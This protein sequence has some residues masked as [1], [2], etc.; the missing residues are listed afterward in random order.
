MRVRGPHGDRS[1]P[2]EELFCLPGDT[3]HIEH[4]LRPGELLLEVVVPMADARLA[5]RARYLKVRDRSSYEFAVVSAAAALAI[6]DGTIRSARIACGGVGT[7]PWRMRACE[8]ALVGRPATREAFQ[9]AARLSV[10]GARPLSGNRFKVELLPR[11]IV[12]ALE[13]VIGDVK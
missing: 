10:E 5:S 4:T 3:P 8:Q 6:E 13:M 9:Q 12:A 11:T 1:F 7:R 2:V